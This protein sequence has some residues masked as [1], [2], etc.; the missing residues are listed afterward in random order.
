MDLNQ[1]KSNQI[2]EMKPKGL[3][4]RIPNLAVHRAEAT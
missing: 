3:A 2:N 4:K 1:I